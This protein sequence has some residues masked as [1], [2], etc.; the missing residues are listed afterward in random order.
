MNKRNSKNNLN[1]NT[2]INII[3][4]IILIVP[5][6]FNSYFDYNGDNHFLQ[7]FF[8]ALPYIL[9]G[10]GIIFIISTTEIKE[11]NNDSKNR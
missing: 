8:A 1:K 5:I 11:N 9:T 4:W 7:F 6:F 10:L 2:I 3:G